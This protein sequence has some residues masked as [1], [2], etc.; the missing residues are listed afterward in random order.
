MIDAYADDGPITNSD[1]SV[2]E[3]SEK[4]TVKCNEV[5]RWT[6]QNRLKIN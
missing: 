6:R 1:P 5:N 4:L 3:I 2:A